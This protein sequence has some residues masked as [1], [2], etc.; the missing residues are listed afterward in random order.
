MVGF[1]YR[2]PQNHPTGLFGPPAFWRQ[3]FFEAHKTTG[4]QMTTHDYVTSWRRRQEAKAIS[5][6]FGGGGKHLDGGRLRPDGQLD[7]EAVPVRR[8]GKGALR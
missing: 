5:R 1:R 7:P 4:E 3:L 6:Y 2:A 8:P